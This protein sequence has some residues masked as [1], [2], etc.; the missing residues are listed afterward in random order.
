MASKKALN[1]DNL[2][3]LGAARLAELLIEVG[4]GNAA[5]KRRLWNWPAPRAPLR[6]PKKSVN[7]WRRS[8]G[9]A[10]SLT[11]KVG[12]RWLTIWTQRVGLSSSRWPHG[13]RPKRRI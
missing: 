5:I 12:N 9:R 3:P 7:A 4:E 6:L 2:E 1:A 11:G 13:C 8:R 10:H